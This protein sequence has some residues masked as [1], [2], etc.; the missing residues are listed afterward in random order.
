MPKLA[1]IT[2]EAEQCVRSSFIANNELGPL[3]PI[4]P[5]AKVLDLVVDVVRHAMALA[6]DGGM[7]AS[8]FIN[9]MTEKGAHHVVECAHLLF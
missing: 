8:N 6:S 1:N 4:G 5:D 9:L 3:G 7:S 2:I